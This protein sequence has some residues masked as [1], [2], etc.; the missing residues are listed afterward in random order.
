MERQHC[1]SFDRWHHPRKSAATFGPVRSRF[2]SR[3]GLLAA[4]GLTAVLLVSC[5]QETPTEYSSE[6][7]E[8]F[9]AACVDA[10][11]DGIFQQRVCR[12]V[13]DE[14]VETIPFERFLEINEALEEAEA[15]A[16]PEDLLDVVAGCAI[17]E[18]DL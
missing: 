8:A 10:E 3:S 2:R 18:G 16:L 11:V 6:N 5:G 13:Y 4:A 12:C 7:Q 9:M 1:T 15:A 17:E 14:A